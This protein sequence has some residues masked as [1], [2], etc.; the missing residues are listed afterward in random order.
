VVKKHSSLLSKIAYIFIFV[1]AIGVLVSFL[2]GIRFLVIISSSMA[3]SIN[4]GDI[5]VSIPTPEKTS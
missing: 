3:P 4:I 2:L 5:I 1:L